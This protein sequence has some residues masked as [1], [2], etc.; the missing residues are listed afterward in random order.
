MQTLYSMWLVDIQ[1]LCWIQ[2]HFKDCHFYGFQQHITTISTELDNV[3]VIEH[4]FLL[5]I[6]INWIF[7]YLAKYPLGLILDDVFF[8]FQLARMQHMNHTCTLRK[9]KTLFKHC[10]VLYDELV[11]TKVSV[12]YNSISRLLYSL[13]NIN[14]QQVWC[15]LMQTPTSLHQI[16]TDTMVSAWCCIKLAV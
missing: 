13:Y 5:I 12:E 4:Q 6:M 8:I 11:Y 3:N 16:E 14:T 9:R 2:I 1:S 7:V 10:V 15:N